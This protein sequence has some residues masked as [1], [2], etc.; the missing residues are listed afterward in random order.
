MFYSLKNQKPFQTDSDKAV[1]VIHNT[2]IKENMNHL[3][4]GR[5][6]IIIT[7]IISMQKFQI[8]SLYKPIYVMEKNNQKSKVE[9]VL[10]H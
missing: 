9:S 5:E 4:H 2:K 7:K 3:H 10:K 6:T 1:V 8:A